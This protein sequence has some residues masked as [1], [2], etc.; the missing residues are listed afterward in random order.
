MES[1]D[2]YDHP[3]CVVVIERGRHGK[4]DTYYVIPEGAP[5]IFK[6]SKG[7]ELTRYVCNL[8]QKRYVLIPHYL[9][10]WEISRKATDL[11]ASDLLLSKILG[12]GN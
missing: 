12:E 9:I 4:K 8:A 6:D 10:G 1:T 2:E 5:V 3:P 7:N 11:G